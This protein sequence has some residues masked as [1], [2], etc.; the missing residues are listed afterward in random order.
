MNVND[1]RVKNNFKAFFKELSIGKAYEDEDGI[2]CIKTSSSEENDNCICFPA[3]EWIA[4][5][6]ALDALVTPLTTTLEIER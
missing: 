4:H 5:I 1:K 2:L 3:D 6:E